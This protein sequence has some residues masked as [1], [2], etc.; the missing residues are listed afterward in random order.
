MRSLLAILLFMALVG[1]AQG[2]INCPPTKADSL[3]P[4]YT[5]DAPV[6]SVLGTGYVLQGTVR[7]S[8]DC[9]IIPEARIE[10]WQAG[11][12][13]KYADA[14]RATVVADTHGQYRLETVRP[15]SYSSRPPHIH[16]RVEVPGYITL[17]TQHYPEEAAEA[18]F[19]LILVPTEN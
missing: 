11:P 9:G 4:F 10:T 18:T 5:P 8:V 7:S 17:V 13:G 1:H 6:R 2:A 3:G 19:D 14:Y 16:I 12:D 15:P